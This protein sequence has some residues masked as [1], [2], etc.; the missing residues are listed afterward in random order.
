MLGA[1][2][3]PGQAVMIDTVGRT[4][5]HE[6]PP[7]MLLRRVVA[8][9]VDGA[10]CAV[11]SSVIVWPLAWGAASEALTSAGFGSFLDFLDA[12]PGTAEAGSAAAAAVQQLQP[13]VV[14]ALLLQLGIAWLYEVV[15]LSLT[16]STPGKG[17]LR[18][19]VVRH[20]PPA[21]V[22][23]PLSPEARPS[24][25]GRLVRMALRTALVVG[26]PALAATMLVAAWL[27]AP[28]ATDLA[29]VTIALTLVFGVVWLAGGMGAH[30]LL[31]RTAV[32]PFSWAQA[33]EAGEQY[34]RAEAADPARRRQV[35]DLTGRAE[36]VGRRAAERATASGERA[37]Q[38]ART[39]ADR[40]TASG[41][42][43]AQS[44]PGLQQALGERGGLRGMIA[45]WLESSGLGD[46]LAEALRD[47]G[48]SS[49]PRSA[50]RDGTTS[51]PPR[52]AGRDGPDHD[53]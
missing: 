41:A 35:A 6:H 14:S 10:L 23:S 18:M 37:V 15:F 48:A 21:A 29:E 11:L 7:A 51:S 24:R 28:G 12:R 31:S 2:D 25:A 19:R 47:G 49:P 8:R 17:L 34:L 30:G 33:R 5:V 26:P 52:S 13:V 32:V 43:T 44:S 53:G 45:Q 3:D 39:S 4:T 1:H 42:R 38:R 20:D 22:I 40:A 36:R 50:G 46:R 16:G 9:G 27:D